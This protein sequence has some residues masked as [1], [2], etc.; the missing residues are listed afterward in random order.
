MKAAYVPPRVLALIQEAWGS[1]EDAPEHIRTFAEAEQFPEEFRLR[2]IS[3]YIDRTRQAPLTPAATCA[4][5]DLPGLPQLR[6]RRRRAVLA[7]APV[8]ANRG[9]AHRPG[10][11]DPLRHGP[12]GERQHGSQGADE[13]DDGGGAP[14]GG[15]AGQC[16][17]SLPAGFLVR[18]QGLL[19][20]LAG[21]PRLM[22]STTFP[23]LS[24][25]M[26]TAGPGAVAPRGACGS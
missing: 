8:V 26:A 25:T 24:R 11:P 12:A 22:H 15:R 21:Q 23:A 18:A 2:M 16:A 3:G 5:P 13:G 4:K 17:A 10:R 20:L 9:L 7:P 6:P 19:A 1:L 14:H